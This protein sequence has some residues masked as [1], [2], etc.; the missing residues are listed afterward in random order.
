MQESLLNTINTTQ[1]QKINVEE[2]EII[3]DSNLEEVV[4][5]CKKA[6]LKPK[7]DNSGN[8][9]FTSED[10]NTLKKMK[11]L[12]KQSKEIQQAAPKEN[13]QETVLETAKGENVPLD[14]T[15]NK[16]NFL[17]RAKNRIKESSIP[18]NLSSYPAYQ[19]KTAM[20]KLENNL[21]S[22]MSEILSEKW[23]DSM[24]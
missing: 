14:S 8:A 3:L 13:I 12:Y 5:L 21:I 22:K 23:M 20:D 1:D 17:T 6:Y 24:K 10:V 19:I 9:Y 16:I 15:E 11:M 7:T 2:L 4:N 18:T